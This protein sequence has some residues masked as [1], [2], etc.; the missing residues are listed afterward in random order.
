VT[1]VTDLQKYSSEKV[2]KE[3]FPKKCSK[4][5][6]KNCAVAT[7][8]FNQPNKVATL[9]PLT[10][11][12]DNR[13]FHLCQMHANRISVPTDWKLERKIDMF[14]PV[15]DQLYVA[16]NQNA[17]ISENNNSEPEHL[18]DDDLTVIM[19]QIV[20]PHDNEIPEE[21]KGTRRGNLVALRTGDTDASM[22]NVRKNLDN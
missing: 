22:P 21:F 11:R 2:L 1:Q 19:R 15:S 7:L 6:C 18:V 8:D 10:D 17:S 20:R 3:M 9:L 4:P 5:R 13:S 14:D 12:A 16:T